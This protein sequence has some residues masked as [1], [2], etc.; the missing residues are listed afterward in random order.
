MWH[1]NETSADLGVSWVVDVDKPYALSAAADHPIAGALMELSRGTVRV[2]VKKH[3]DG[4]PV[5]FGLTLIVMVVAIGIGHLA[6]L[7]KASVLAA[8]V[9]LFC[10]LGSIS[11]ALRPDLRRLAW[12]APV[13]LVAGC[14]P[15]ALSAW[16]SFVG[17]AAIAAIVFVIALAPAISERLRVAT[18]GITYAVIAG[19]GVAL[20]EGTPETHIVA[21]V[22][23]GIGIA[24]AARLLIGVADPSA[25]T[26]QQLAAPFIDTDIDTVDVLRSWLLDAPTTWTTEV[27]DAGLRY[28]R[29][30]TLLTA[31]GTDRQTCAAH[32]HALRTTVATLNT[33]AAETAQRVLAQ[34]PTTAATPTSSTR[35]VDLANLP[36]RARTLATEALHQLARANHAATTRDTTPASGVD[37]LRSIYLRA[38]LRSAMSPGSV[39]LSHA[40]AKSVGVLAAWATGLQLS[41][42]A[43]TNTYFNAIVSMLQPTWSQTLARVLY[44]LAGSAIAVV[45]VVSA[46]LWLPA[47]VMLIVAVLGLFTLTWFLFSHPIVS[48][49]GGTAMTV[50]ITATTQHLQPLT[51]LAHLA[52]MLTVAAIIVVLA[53][54]PTL[55][56]ARKQS[57]TT[58][59]HTAREATTALLDDLDTDQPRNPATQ[60]ATFLHGTH[61]AR[62]IRTHSALLP[63]ADQAAGTTIADDIEALTLLSTIYLDDK[64]TAT[65]HRAT[66]RAA[67]RLIRGDIT[68]TEMSYDNTAAPLLLCVNDIA[69]HCRPPINDPR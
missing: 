41:E 38:R 45:L 11:G 12:L 60:F 28:R 55:L 65:E 49:A 24:V 18:I 37:S 3:T 26:R 31:H 63:D 33:I 40:S 66:V 69:R 67:Q 7:G 61:L 1:V 19:Y 36:E 48:N 4:G 29:I 54:L 6:G 22:A 59:L 10:V 8:L 56:T 62:Q 9:G 16:N 17:I 46:A 50:A 21:A 25:H 43:L 35:S 14:V 47:P 52:I 5:L 32:T 53:S 2:S 64:T 23:L 15:R 34:Q 42:P 44:R 68:E 20:P 30:I 13:L 39:E 51:T 58:L 27:L 57:L